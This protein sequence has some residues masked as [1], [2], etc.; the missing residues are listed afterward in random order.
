MFNGENY[1]YIWSIL[2]KYFDDE[3]KRQEIKFVIPKDR[4][5]P[6]VELND[7]SLSQNIIRS[8]EIQVNPFLRF[9]GMYIQ[10]Q[11]NDTQ[12]EIVS[13]DSFNNILLHLFG[14]LDLLEGLNGYDIFLKL[15]IDEIERGEFG[16]KAKENFKYLSRSEKR[17]IAKY[18]KKYYVQDNSINIFLRAFKE[19]FSDSIVYYNKSKKRN[20]LLYINE[21]DLEENKKKVEV[22]KGF[23]LPFEYK[24]KVMWKYH[25]G[26]MGVKETMEIKK[27]LIL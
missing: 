11:E 9:E 13:K 12:K 21:E 22:L 5:S 23:F 15:I 2:Q 27:I 3:V 7:E 24:I 18:I 19:I 6:Y 1:K 26:V 14:R 4:I 10:N 17:I 16:E 8:N 20:I 25:V